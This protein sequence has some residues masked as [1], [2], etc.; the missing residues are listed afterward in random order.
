[1]LARFDFGF[2]LTQAAQRRRLH[3]CEQIRAGAA[4]RAMFGANIRV[5][6]HFSA[7]PVCERARQRHRRVR[8]A[9]T[10]IRLVRHQQSDETN[11]ENCTEKHTGEPFA[12][13]PSLH[14]L[15]LFVRD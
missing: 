12:L 1:M 5:R 2:D 8:T 6:L 9:V 4:R 10:E 15:H 13:S 7:E 11:P 14:I 3:T